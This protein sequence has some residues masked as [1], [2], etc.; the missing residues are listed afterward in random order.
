M[1]WESD[2][3]FDLVSQAYL[4]IQFISCVLI[5]SGWL[6]I[7]QS[8]H[9]PIWYQVFLPEPACFSGQSAIAQNC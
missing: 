4:Q 1:F 6:I 9:N 5:I 3:R 7:L 8:G 2:P